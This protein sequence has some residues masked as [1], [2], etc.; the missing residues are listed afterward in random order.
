VRATMHSIGTYLIDILDGKQPEG[1]AQTAAAGIFVAQQTS[2]AHSD[3]YIGAS[4][5][6]ALALAL[7]SILFVF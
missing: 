2:N 1:I 7:A 5:I 6:L 3:A 4:K